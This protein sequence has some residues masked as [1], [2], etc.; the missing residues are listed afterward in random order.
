MLDQR[1]VKKSSKSDEKKLETV[2]RYEQKLEISL[3]TSD[4]V[5]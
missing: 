3:Y 5:I 1:K 2:Y 4:T